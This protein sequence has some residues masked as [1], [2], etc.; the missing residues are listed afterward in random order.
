MILKG[1]TPGYTSFVD[2]CNT[3]NI[4]NISRKIVDTQGKRNEILLTKE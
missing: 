1:R 3:E 4:N 2:S